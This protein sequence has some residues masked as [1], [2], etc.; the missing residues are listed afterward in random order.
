M[1]VQT[2][3]IT[4]AVP[5]RLDRLP[6]SKFHWRVL[7]GLG[8]VWILDGLEVTI[9]GSIAAR[10]TEPGSGISLSPAD[11]GF[12]AACYVAGACLGALFFGQLTDRFGRKKLFL[13]TLAVYIAA[14]VATAFAFAPWFFFVMRFLTGSGIGGEY[15]AINSAIDELIP[16][17]VRGRVDLVINGTYWAGSAAGSA[18]ALLLL[19]TGIFPADIGWRVAFGLGAVL[20]LVILIVRRH[21]PESPR[22]LF[23]HGR[24]EEAERIVRDIESDVEAQTGRSLDEVD[25]ELTVRQ[26]KS[27]P[28]REIARTAFK[29][30]PRRAVLG[31]ALFV[32]Q[33]FIYN[34]IT[35]NLGTLFS[36]YYGVA[37]G[38]VPVFVVVYAVGNLLGPLTLGR[39]FDTVGRK[40]MV[41]G[42]YLGSALLT[43]PLIWVFVTGSGGE[44]AVLALIVGT[45]FL[46][47]AGASAAYLT[48][49]EIFPMETR[50]LAIA[51]FYAVGTGLGGIAGPLLFGRLI[52]SGDRGLVA[53]AFGVGAVAMALGGVAEL[54]FGVRAER[55]GLESIAKPLTADEEEPE[56][57]GEPDEVRELRSQAARTRAAAAEHRA[58]ALEADGGQDGRAGRREQ[59]L[60]E[61]AESQASAYDE[62]AAAAAARAEADQDEEGSAARE[63][64]LA[65]A[66]AA[67]RRAEAAGARAE[68][69]T[70]R[71]DERAAR[72]RQ[73]EEADELSRAA[74][75][76]AT[77]AD[78]RH[79]AEQAGPDEKAVP[80]AR[81]RVH[82]AWA[83][84]HR[85]QAAVLAAEAADDEP[86]AQRHERARADAERSA[87]AA[88]QRLR[89]A[90]LTA[91][92]AGTEP[93]ETGSAP[94]PEPDGAAP[95]SG[96]LRRWRPGPGRGGG[97]WSSLDDTRAR[98][99]AEAEALGH[100]IESIARAVAEHGPTDRDELARIVGARYWGPGRFGQALRV[101][102]QEGAV[103]RLSGRSY[104]PADH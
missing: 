100:E 103:R 24:Q 99:A 29:R 27:I 88:E 56:E 69:A 53:V 45:F 33:A 34:G 74:E 40:P 18:A 43:V 96:G 104:G 70:C 10:L 59:E 13:V 78:A 57:D 83:R 6:W 98:G 55:A 85:E 47:S 14:T 87:L 9:V 97:L 1:S 92:A 49:S 5:A 36:G 86:A 95:P 76:Q 46:A 50:A 89:A 39:L 3:T 15:A 44:W 67:D 93:A 94:A 31:I 79:E 73:A 101:A 51:F 20:G 72:L 4:T 84:M 28:F 90:E 61:Q 42:T 102:L 65:R 35:F 38:V 41:A 17:R 8:T 21:V 30:Y 62:L 75:Q 16:A 66:L 48:V 19:D 82:L 12:A 58:R 71:G 54:A 2:A 7:I 77:A 25:D 37:S 23:I 26:R 11:I 52:D 32:G 80:E 63:A 22:W 81:S 60:A 91:E 64:A 68:A